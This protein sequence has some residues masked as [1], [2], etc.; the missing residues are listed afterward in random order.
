[1]GKKTLVFNRK[2]RPRPVCLPLKSR[3]SYIG[4]EP[5]SA[6]R[7]TAADSLLSLFPML[8][9]KTSRC[10]H[11]SPHLPTS[12]S[13]TTKR[14]RTERRTVLFPLFCASQ[15]T[16]KQGGMKEPARSVQHASVPPEHTKAYLAY[17][18]MVTLLSS[19]HKWMYSGLS[20]KYSVLLL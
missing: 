20:T 3:S 19:K 6:C 12:S 7:L 15:R 10:Q 18:A 11:Q 16:R 13:T 4:Q 2:L 8:N 1:M 14:R 9:L 17:I 5:P